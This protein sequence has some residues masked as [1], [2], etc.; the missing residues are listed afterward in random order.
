MI[1]AKIEST[2]YIDIYIDNYVKPFHDFL[3]DKYLVYI[4]GLADFINVEDHD[5]NYLLNKLQMYGFE[6]TISN[7]QDTIDGIQ[8]EY[9][10]KKNGKGL[11]EHRIENLIS[12]IY[13]SSKTDISIVGILVMQIVSRII[14]KSKTELSR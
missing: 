2:K 8:V 11:F 4:S 12:T 5:V 7:G 9:S 10:Y 6:V 1:M 3:T 14:C 13:L